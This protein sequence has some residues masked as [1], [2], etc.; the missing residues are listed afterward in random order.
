MIEEYD[1]M[2]SKDLE[3]LLRTIVDQGKVNIDGKVIDFS[4]A[5]FIITSNEDHCSLF[6]C[7]SDEPDKDKTGSRT[8]IKHDITAMNR[9]K[10]IEFD[11]LSNEDY[12]QLAKKLFNEVA[13]NYK[14]KYKITVNT[15]GMLDG[16]ANKAEKINRGARPIINNIKTSLIYAV[17][18]TR[19][20]CEG[21]NS[22]KASYD[23]QKGE[24][25]ITGV[26][27]KEGEDSCESVFPVKFY[28][29]ES[30]PNEPDEVSSLELDGDKEEFVDLNTIDFPMTLNYVLQ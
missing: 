13:E 10:L 4:K 20:N 29:D 11:N 1:K 26:D 15:D 19:K 27:R 3:N 2:W 28:E 18:K 24:I 30:S 16:T 14:N 7:N 23:E 17:N 5:I 25:K 6:N 12:K 21:V 9:F 22:F 8:K